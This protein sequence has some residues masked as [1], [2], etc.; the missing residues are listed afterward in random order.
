MKKLVVTALV[1]LL[2]ALGFSLRIGFSSFQMGNDW[3][4]QLWEGAEKAMKA[5][6]WEVVHNNAEGDTSRQL[7]AL[8][9]FLSAR[10]DAVIIGGGEGGALA[11]AIAKLSIAGIPVITVDNISEHSYVSIIPNN[12]QSTEALALFLVNKLQREG[13]V[14]HLTIPG[15]GWYTVTIRDEIAQKIFEIEGMNLVGILDSGLAD[16]VQKSMNAVRSTMLS[17]PDL[18]AVYCSWGMPALGAVN[19]IR[20]AGKQKDVFV[21]CTDADRP[22]LLEMMKDDSPLAAVAAQVP[23]VMGEL[24]VEFAYK[25]VVEK[26]DVAKIAYPP[27]YIVTKEPELV[28][29]G[30]G[31]LSPDEA[32][33]MIYPGVPKR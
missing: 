9:G 6:G 26:A 5:Q 3:N 2:C 8:E 14:V 19:A 29:P 30:I 28:P 20:A 13:K 15:L 27:M 22:V 4:I 33:D 21:V 24:A 17:H 25:A 16:A 31:V 18:K 32:W 11:P 12:Y 1:V 10:V 23:F 7:A